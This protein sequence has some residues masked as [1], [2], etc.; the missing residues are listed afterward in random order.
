MPHEIQDLVELLFGLRGDRAVVL[1]RGAGVT[2]SVTSGKL[3]LSTIEIGCCDLMLAP[4]HRRGQT[5]IDKM[6]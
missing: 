6:G 2:P 4:F 5:I 3:R 1:T